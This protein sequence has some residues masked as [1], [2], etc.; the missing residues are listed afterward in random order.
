MIGVLTDGVSSRVGGVLSFAVVAISSGFIATALLP[1]IVHMLQQGGLT[2]NNFQGAQ[3][4]SGVGILFPIATLIPLS[5]L[6]IFSTNRVASIWITVTFGMGFIGLLD[7]AAGDRTVRGLK[8]HLSALIQLKPTTGSVKAVVG[9]MLSLFAGWQ[10][11]GRWLDALLSAALIALSTNTINLLDVRP[12]RALKGFFL[13]TAIAIALIVPVMM[14]PASSAGLRQAWDHVIALGAPLGVAAA[15]WSPDLKAKIMLGDS[16]SNVLGASTGLL[17]ASTSVTSQL[18]VLLTL[19]SLHVVA[20]RSSITEWI[21]R[22][23][24]LDRLDRWGR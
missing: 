23:P 15:L 13:L 11:H 24:L 7:D 18:A 17:F 1:G 12:G 4:P 5:A 6:I 3:I 19:V 2:R 21:E 14:T 20:E 9:G 10:L 16:G 22:V 8:G